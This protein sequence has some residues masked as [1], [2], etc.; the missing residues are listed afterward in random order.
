M[1]RGSAEPVAIVGM[2]VVLPGAGSLEAYWSN[3]V[4]GVDAISEAPPLRLHPEHYDPANSHRADRLYCRRGGFVDEFAYFDP[5][6][7]GVMPASVAGTEPEQLIALRVAAAAI[8]DA[9]GLDQLGAPD[10]IGVILGR[11]GYSGL[12]HIKFVSRVRTPD[13]L[14]QTLRELLPEV[15]PERLEQVRDKLDE[16]FGP[17]HPES[18]INLVPNLVASR[19]A[20]RLNLRGPAY[21]VD[22]ACA[23]SLLAVDH[24]IVQLASGRL[25]SVLAGGVHHVHD[26]GFWAI[27]NQIGG[28]S[29]RGEIRPFDVSADGLLMGEGTGVVVLRRL[30][31]AIRDGNRVYAVIRGIGTSSD[32][33]A[34]SLVNP[35]TTGQSIAVRRA[36]AAAGLDP[37]APDSLGLLEAHGTA[38]PVGDGVELTTIADV[39]GPPRDG[40]PPVLGSVKSMIGHAMPAAGVAGLVKAVLAVSR[41]MLL[42]TLHCDNPRPELAKTRFVTIDEARPWDGAGPRRAGV[43]AFGFGGINAH[44]I[45]EEA[46]DRP[47]A[48]RPAAEPAAPAPAP[49]VSAAQVTAAQVTE[50]DEIVLLGGP[51]PAAVA[52][53]LDADDQAIRAR[54]RSRASAGPDGPGGPAGDQCRLGIVGPTPARLAAARKVVAAGQAWRGGRDIWFSPRPLLA[55]GA[56]RIAYVFSGLEAEFTPRLDDL[57]A[58][59]GLDT[60]E[61]GGEGFAGHLS[62]VVRVGWLLNDVLERIGVT[63]DALAGHSLG[64]WTAILI[65]GLI[66]ESR[67]SEYATTMLAESGAERQDLL[68]AVIGDSAPAI[69]ARLGGYPGVVLSMDNAPAQSVVCGPVDQVTRLM[70]DLGRENTL[71]RAL[72]FTTGVHTP[73]LEPMVELLRQVGGEEIA[74]AAKERSASKEVWSATTVSPIP[75]DPGE[76]RDLFF[77]QL[78]EPVRFR[79]TVE[80]MY[81]AGVR[82]FLQVGPGQLASLVHDNLRERDHLAMPVNVAFR[83]GID[84]MRRVLTA[85]WVEGHAADLA[86]LDPAGRVAPSP[87]RLA[88]PDQSASADQPASSAQS[89]SPTPPGRAARGMP[90]LLDLGWDRVSLGEGASKLLDIP[91]WAVSAGSAAGTPT[92]AGADAGQDGRTTAVATLGRLADRSPA[93][94]ELAALL[95]DTAGAAVAVLAAAGPRSGSGTAP[96]RPAAPASRPASPGGTPPPE[97][98][99]AGPAGNG[100]GVTRTTLRLSLAAMPHLRDHCF[101]RQ[102]DDWPYEEDRF[103]VVPA[104]TIIGHLM[105]AAEAAAPGQRAVRVTGARFSRWTLGEPPSDIEVTVKPAGPN[106]FAATFGPNAR[107]TVHTAPDYPDDPPALW[108]HDPATEWP[109]PISAERYYSERYTFHGPSISG[110]VAVHAVG[111]MHVRGLL[112]TPGVPGGLLDSGLVMLGNWLRVTQDSRQISFPLSFG[113]IRFFGPHPAEGEMIECVSRVTALDDRDM[114]FGVQFARA[115]GGP[116]WAVLEDGL[117]RRF[118]TNPRS[119]MAEAFPGHNAASVSQPGGWVMLFDCWP[120]PGT[121]LTIAQSSLGSRGFGEF[122]RQ[123]IAGRKRWLMGQ[124]A[125]KDAARRLMWDDG[126]DEVFPIEVRV[127]DLGD[128]RADVLPW[129]ERNIPAFGASYAIAREAAVAMAWPAGTPAAPGATAAGIGVADIDDSPDSV[130]PELSGPELSDPEL[131]DPE[132]D[133]LEAAVAAE[134]GAGRAVWLARFR[135]AR[136]AA[137]GPLGISPADRPGA[138]TVTAAGPEVITVTAEGRSC[139]VSHDEIRNPEGLPER[140]YAVA[141][142]SAPQDARR[143]RP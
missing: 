18:V 116:V 4:N 101:F 36:W 3:L 71:C 67:L 43:N 17:L 102:P 31:D 132:R 21:T 78:L 81:D 11:G 83:S 126:A 7:Y 51:D 131:S 107:A 103:P 119:R 130:G 112:R 90:M 89:A 118:D 96:P 25:D 72:P 64:E 16:S 62:D 47:R 87:A 99:A 15:S 38:T 77:R 136:Q 27:F 10:R 46:P 127:S 114:A 134:P 53:L 137:A 122:D 49:A 6:A 1:S 8:E 5:M 75:Q 39:F 2:E 34:A 108:Q 84:Q 85:L 104:T 92:A 70:Q 100:A 125:V 73:Y 48:R 14:K 115:N 142:A 59:F 86:A 60:G 133:V 52:A 97:P 128:G 105:A 111:K 19:I 138:L 113:S 76:R 9:G 57:S 42:P 65:A 28:L 33:R 117:H 74:S 143:T 66:D 41:G 121:L 68:H 26:I 13:Q 141:W 129:P 109:T 79:P 110:V 69:T 140:R 32:G 98:P 56:G 120:H 37:A 63:P 40:A 139:A 94:A 58:H 88:D 24:A 135:A 80:A 44:V 12:S 93:T 29:R 35:E 82:V 20:N 95:E 91:G 106:Q 61:L 45:V 55:D 30:S 50:P 54:G 22:G 123:P 23:S 124:I